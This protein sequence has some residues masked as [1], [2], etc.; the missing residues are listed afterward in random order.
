MQDQKQSHFCAVCQKDA[1]PGYISAF[2]STSQESKT[3]WM[4][5]IFDL[6]NWI[7]GKYW[8]QMWFPPISVEYTLRE[9]YHVLEL[10]PKIEHDIVYVSYISTSSIGIEVE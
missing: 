5:R 4:A 2:Q 6:W 1:M 7:I 9:G 8:V 3:E 10:T